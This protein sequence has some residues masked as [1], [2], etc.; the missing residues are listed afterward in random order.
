MTTIQSLRVLLFVLACCL[1]GIAAYLSTDLP[2]KLT[3]AAF[4]IVVLAWIIP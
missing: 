4:A 2:N 1:F 3:R